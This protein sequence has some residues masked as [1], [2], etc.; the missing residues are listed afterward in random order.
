MLHIVIFSLVYVG[1]AAAFYAYLL[2]EARP[3]PNMPDIRRTR[4]AA[5]PKPSLHPRVSGRYHAL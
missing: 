4:S 5:E 1:A 3:M 2:A